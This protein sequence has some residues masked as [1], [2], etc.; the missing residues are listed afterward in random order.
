[1]DRVTTLRRARRTWT[2]SGID[3][4]NRMAEVLP[5]AEGKEVKSWP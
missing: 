1:M 2:I 4:L 5:N 3:G